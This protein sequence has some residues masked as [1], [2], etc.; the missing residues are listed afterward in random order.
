MRYN[1]RL[2]E[3][4]FFKKSKERIT[5]D[6]YVGRGGYIREDWWK[7]FLKA[8][9]LIRDHEKAMETAKQS[10]QEKLIQVCMYSMY[11]CTKALR[12]E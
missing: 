3:I 4:L 1:A 8:S 6:G 11:V 9:H 7:P 12:E 5:S 2:L 10:S